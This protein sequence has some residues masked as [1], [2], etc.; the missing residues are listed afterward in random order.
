M[1]VSVITPDHVD[2]SPVDPLESTMPVQ[3]VVHVLDFDEL[4]RDSHDK[5]ILNK[6]NFIEPGYAS[7]LSEAIFSRASDVDFVARC[8]CEHLQGNFFIGQVCP[9]C[10]TPVVLD[11]DTAT[12]YLQHRAW[13]ECPKEIKGWLNPSAFFVLSKW[14]SYGKKVVAN[15]TN[16]KGDVASKG[17]RK[18][19]NYLEDILDPN[20][21]IP[22]E[23]EGIVLGKGFNY[24]Y[25]NF[26]YLMDFFLHSFKKTAQKKDAF[27]IEQYIKKHRDKI[28]C[29]YFPVL[30]SALHS[31][32]M[33][34][35]TRENRKRYVD[36]ICQYVQHAAL[37]LSFLEFSPRKYPRPDEIEASTFAAFQ[38]II[39]YTST[40]SRKHLSV[41]RGLPRMHIFGS[42]LHLSARSV[43]VPITGM[44]AMDELHFPWA[45]GVNMMRVDL[46]GILMR[47]YG[48]TVADA[49]NLQQ[50]AL[51]QFDPLINQLIIRLIQ[52]CP[53]KGIPVLWNRNPTVR[54]GGV[55]LRFWTH[56]K[57]DPDDET[58]AMSTMSMG[59]LNADCDGDA[60][61]AFRVPEMEAVKRFMALHPANLYVSNN[62]MSVQS[63]LA[64]PKLMTLPAN[65]FLGR[66]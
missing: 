17:K 2:E 31:V 34:E 41:K 1:N 30:S 35:G 48:M 7:S 40:I 60:L 26:D 8:E 28:F 11:M 27:F 47:E 33:S 63:G 37:A 29:R 6:F 10:G 24:L 59:L 57:T 49:Y 39:A 53:Y 44:H 45:L 46:I 16:A 66:I 55:D 21:D 52:E 62:E 23:L 5:V 18:K 9:E 43:I 58:I 20:T 50:A 51:V 15:Y 56:L 42:R 12:G 38:N 13:L 4:Y 3:R 25:D 32:V 64:V 36:K 19:G 65:G 14:L 54:V 22:E 61:N